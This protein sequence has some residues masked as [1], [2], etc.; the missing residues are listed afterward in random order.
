MVKRIQVGGLLVA[1]Q[2]H[3]LIE[4][5]IL[6]GTGIASADFWQGFEQILADYSDRN[7]DLLATRGEVATPD[8]RMALCRAGGK[9]TITRRTSHS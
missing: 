5:E 9:S 1:A 8:Q 4:T 3:D 7:K 2:L 6:P